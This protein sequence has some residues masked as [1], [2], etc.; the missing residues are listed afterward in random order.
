MDAAKRSEF[1][2]PSPQ[3]AP[4]R[5]V[6]RLKELGNQ[7]NIVAF[8]LLREIQSFWA[9]PDYWNG[10]PDTLKAEI[11]LTRSL[12]FD[13]FYP[14]EEDFSRMNDQAE[15]HNSS[16]TRRLKGVIQAMRTLIGE[17]VAIW[18]LLGET[19]DKEL[20]RNF[21]DTVV[22]M[23]LLPKTEGGRI[24]SF[25]SARVQT[26]S[27]GYDSASWLNSTIVAGSLGED[28]TSEQVISGAGPG[29][30]EAANYGAMEGRWHIL[31]VLEQRLAE[32]SE[33]DKG[34]IEGAI[35]NARS[36]IHSMGVR[37]ALPFEASWNKHLQF[38]LTIKNFAPRKEALVAATVGRSISHNGS[39][40]TEHQRHPGVFIFP[41]GFGTEDE[42]WEVACLIQCGK[43]PEIPMFAVGKD[44]SELV[45]HGVEHMTQMNTISPDDNNIIIE[46][47]D[48]VE[49]V[50][51]YHEYHGLKQ[52]E[53]TKKA[54]HD[55]EPRIN[56]Q[57]A[58]STNGHGADRKRKT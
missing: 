6:E 16:G 52:S 58:L 40:H 46:C 47:A 22:A 21:Q 41:G 30:M 38:G 28:G 56:Y 24:V 12:A 50:I 10:L 7:N 55:R 1:L 20:I 15:S 11:Q 44:A 2:R 42:K 18:G 19:Y 51:K 26:A 45:H 25:G 48:E 13:G 37:I 43:M 36:Q 17:Q 34:A 57:E 23:D 3:S 32:A 5:T 31:N 8:H 27:A 33:N 29:Y 39:E 53:Y 14:A 54:I 49:A 9:Q 35:F 4:Q